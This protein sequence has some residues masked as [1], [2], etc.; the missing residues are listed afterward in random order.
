MPPPYAILLALLLH[1]ALPSILGSRTPPGPEAGTLAHLAHSLPLAEDEVWEA[2][3]LEALSEGPVTIWHEGSDFI[4]TGRGSEEA[5]RLRI[6]SAEE[7]QRLWV[8][9]APPRILLKVDPPSHPTE[10]P[11]SETPR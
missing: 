3:S 5:Y 9:V 10:S 7:V 1:F 6:E 8:R 4:A 11:T 2:P